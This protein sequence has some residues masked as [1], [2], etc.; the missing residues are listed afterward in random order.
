[1]YRNQ[2]GCADPTAAA[3]MNKMMHEYRVEQRQK[4]RRW[5]ELKSRPRIYVVSKYAGDVAENVRKARRYCRFAASKQRIPFASH[6][7]YPQFLNDNNPKEREI[8]LQYGMVWLERC[9]EVWCFGTEHS[10]GMEAELH[11]AKTK[12]I[13]IRYFTEE[14]EELK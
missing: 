5:K 11:A 14:M 10:P 3:V 2:S 4:Q 12:H 6:L 1:M 9:D 8:G 7:L 13:P